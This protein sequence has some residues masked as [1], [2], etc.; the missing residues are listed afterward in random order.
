MAI[1]PTLLCGKLIDF[2]TELEDATKNDLAAL[3]AALQ[4]K[5]GFKT[6]PLVASRKFNLRDQQPNERVNDYV[7]DLKC[8]F[9]QAYPDDVKLMKSH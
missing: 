4:E 8:L 6:D 5:A 9:K 7:S 3:K 1:V 2:Y